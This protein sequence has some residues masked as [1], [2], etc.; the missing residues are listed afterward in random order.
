VVAF[1]CFQLLPPFP[2]IPEDLKFETVVVN[3]F[4]PQIRRQI[5]IPG[6]NIDA[7]DG[8][9]RKSEP[10]GQDRDLL[11]EVSARP[12]QTNLLSRTS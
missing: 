3:E 6:R 11:I 9:R 4:L 1:A 7:L 10:C 2:H 8:D 5:L 12:I